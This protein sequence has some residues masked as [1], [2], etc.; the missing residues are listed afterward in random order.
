[1]RSKWLEIEQR[2]EVANARALCSHQ[3]SVAALV[4]D[5][6]SCFG[7]TTGQLL[8]LELDHESVGADGSHRVAQRLVCW[9]ANDRGAGDLPR[10]GRLSDHPID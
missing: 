7:D 4:D 6:Q 10:P 5:T 9:P 8:L 3:W 2:R 1:M